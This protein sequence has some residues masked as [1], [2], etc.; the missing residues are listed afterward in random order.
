MLQA[1]ACETAVRRLLLTTKL[2]AAAKVHKYVLTPHKQS[3]YKYMSAEWAQVETS[4][5]SACKRH[6][7]RLHT[8]HQLLYRETCC[9][10]SST[11]GYGGLTQIKEDGRIQ[12]HQGP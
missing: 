9:T 8:L 2:S 12:G 10:R 7:D 3:G 4:V 11:P 6:S 5:A 1:Q